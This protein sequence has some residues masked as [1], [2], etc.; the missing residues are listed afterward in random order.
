[1]SQK[2]IAAKL[3]LHP[4]AVREFVEGGRNFSHE[5]MLE[6]FE[7]CLETD[8]AIKSGQMGDV[9]AVEVLIIKTCAK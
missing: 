2:D 7:S 9:M 6:A 8:Y 1:M 3:A 5:A 4:F